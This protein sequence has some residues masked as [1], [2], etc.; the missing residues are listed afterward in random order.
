MALIKPNI[1]SRASSV[2]VARSIAFNSALA[3]F[4]TL[5]RTLLP[6]DGVA[7]AAGSG[8]I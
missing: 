5:G 4:V 7:A 3:S 6:W 8:L 2:F 1:T